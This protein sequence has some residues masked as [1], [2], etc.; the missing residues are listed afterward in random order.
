MTSADDRLGSDERQVRDARLVLGA[1]VEPG[2]RQLYE[3]VRAHGPVE[4]LARLAG[5]AV[6]GPLAEAAAVRLNG[7]DPAA[8]AAALAER[9]A[10]LGVRIVTPES[11]QWP[12]QLD[13]LR[14]ISVEGRDT[15]DRDTYPPQCLWV[16]GPH[17][18]HEVAARSVALVGSRANTVYGAHVAA[19]F[20]YGLADR[21]W[22]VI[23]GGAYG[24]DAVAHRAALAAGGLTVSVLA[25][26]V[27][28]PY[29][30]SN[31]ALFEQ[32]AEQG[33]LISEWPPGTAPFKVRFL[34]RNRVIAALA[35]GTVLVEAAARSGARQT[36]RRAR[37]L[38]RAAM[39]V[40]G[41]VTSE[42]SVGCHEELRRDPHESVRAVASVEHVLE[43][44]GGVGELAPVPR[45]R[46]QS[47]DALDPVERQLVD[48]APRRGAAAA[49]QLAYEAGVPLREALAKLPSLALR[50][51][52]REQAG[53]FARA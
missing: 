30:T 11:A 41:P 48:A 3:L 34:V 33:L 38:N 51:H 40:P 21:G 43:E 35:R 12:A 50:G 32:I 4:A 29:P 23:S 27:D 37:Q 20:G 47:L 44:V 42:N 8:I 31:S 49:S 22:T 9:G 45:G 7:R 10:R 17:E 36:L 15:I 14:H 6:T 28:R 13:D 39:A 53:G 19:E 2:G 18:L 52:L 25:C 5:G 1:L 26:G 46:E 16:R 24:I